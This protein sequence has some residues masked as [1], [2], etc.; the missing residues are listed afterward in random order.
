VTK[1]KKYN[2]YPEQKDIEKWKPQKVSKLKFEES[3]GFMF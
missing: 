3:I 2:N 1:S